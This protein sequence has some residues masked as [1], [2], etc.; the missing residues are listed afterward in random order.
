M[1]RQCET[2]KRPYAGGLRVETDDLDSSRETGAVF[3]HRGKENRRPT[4]INSTPSLFLSITSTPLVHPHLP[5]SLD[6]QPQFRRADRA[7]FRY[8]HIIQPQILLQPVRTKR[9]SAASMP[10]AQRQAPPP[11][12]PLQPAELQAWKEAQARVVAQVG[13]RAV[14]RAEALARALAGARALAEV[15]EEIDAFRYD[16]VLADSKLVDIIYSIKP[17]QRQR[18]ARELSKHSYTLQKYWWFIQIVVP[19][20]RLPLE[21]LHQILLIIIDEASHP[22]SVLMRVCKL[23]YTIATGIWAPLKLGT[24]TPKDVVTSTLERNQWFL[25]V[26]VDTEFDRGH[27]SPSERTYDAIFA[28]IRATSRWRTFVVETF[29]PHADFSEHHVSRRLQRCSNAVLSRLRTF[30]IKSA[31]EMSPLLDRLLRILGTSASEE[32]TTIEINSPSVISFLAP[33]YPS[34]FNSVKVLSV[35][36]PGLL[37]PV[38]LLPH[39]HQLEAFTASHLSLPHYYDDV[40]LPFVHTLRHLALRAVSI[41]WMSGRTFHVLESC[42]IVFP[43]HRHVLHTF[44]TTLPNC[45]RLSFHGYPPEILDGVSAHKLT[46]LSVMSCYSDKL[47]GNRQLVWFSNHALRENRLRPLILHISIEAMTQAWIRAL[48]F[49]SNLEELVIECAQPS[50]LGVKS[51]QSLV[52]HPAHADDLDTTPTPSGWSTPAC[53]SLKLFG[54]RY[55]RWL[56]PSEQFDMIPEFMSIIW[57]RQH[58]GFS[59]KRFC[60][61]TSSDQKDPVELIEGSCISVEGFEWL[62]KDGESNLLELVVSRL[63]GNMVKPSG[64]SLLSSV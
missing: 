63:V 20:T 47:R 56:R 29:P 24:T 41:Q 55:R 27:F 35:D 12:P 43:I 32:L 2:G 61:W 52:V 58:S 5:T 40:V 13:T 36:V 64:K 6:M 42:T 10:E 16:E 26:S 51:L 21:L 46:K 30:K 22:P 49:M 1:T 54:L 62:A 57:S 17:Y 59:L 23:W 15:R 25:D 45:D 39:L 14:A 37:D 44:N 3:M 38:D 34:I 9:P 19:I 7:K 4:K 18:L 28:A 11:S 33:T 60:V 53:P 48:D 31:C 8:G 50:S